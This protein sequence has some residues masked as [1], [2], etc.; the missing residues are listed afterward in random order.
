MSWPAR[1]VRIERLSPASSVRAVS[2]FVTRASRKVPCA[3]VTPRLE[4]TLTK[5]LRKVQRP[6][7]MCWRPRSKAST[8]TRHGPQSS[9]EAFGNQDEGEIFFGAPAPLGRD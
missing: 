5:L 6:S 9:R 7:L 8:Q 4:K 1:A 3:R 2:A